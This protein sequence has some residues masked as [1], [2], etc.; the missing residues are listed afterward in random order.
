MPNLIPNS[1]FLSPMNNT[2]PFTTVI[3]FQNYFMLSC[4]EYPLSIFQRFAISGSPSHK[5][6]MTLEW[7]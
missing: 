7:D 1:I 6:I 4:D 2:T 3:K 5:A